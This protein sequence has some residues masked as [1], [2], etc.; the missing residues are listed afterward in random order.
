M[1]IVQLYTWK[2]KKSPTSFPKT[3]NKKTINKKFKD[4]I[5]KNNL[6]GIIIVVLCSIFCYTS[7]GISSFPQMIV[8]FLHKKYVKGDFLIFHK[9]FSLRDTFSIFTLKITNTWNQC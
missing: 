7:L 5:T 8:K 1:F 2:K 3:I 9:T 6:R 4:H